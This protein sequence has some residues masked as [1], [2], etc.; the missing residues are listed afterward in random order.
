MSAVN[1]LI[2]GIIGAIVV[3]IIMTAME[4]KTK[5]V[6]PAILAEKL[7][8]DASKKPMVLFVRFAV[9][10]LI[11]GALIGTS[12]PVLGTVSMGAVGGATFAILPW[13]VLNIVMLP[14]AGAGIGGTKKWNMIP[15]VS[16]V[17]HLV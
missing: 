5:A 8:G 1:G 15:V 3:A 12:L 14:M 4:G 9:W 10:G 7:M 2:G 16:L 6:P 13:L 11:Y 17:G